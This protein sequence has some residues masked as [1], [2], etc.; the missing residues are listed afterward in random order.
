M[1]YKN[2]EAGEFTEIADRTLEET[3]DIIIK[4]PWERERNNTTVEPT[5]PSVSM[6]HPE[7]GIL[8]LGPSYHSKFRLYWL[9]P[10]G[11]LFAKNVFSLDE[12]IRIISGFYNDHDISEG[13]KKYSSF[14]KMTQHFITN[15]FVYTVTPKRILQYNLWHAIFGT[16]F[17]FFTIVAM[18]SQHDVDFWLKLSMI[19][20]PFVI[21]MHFSGVNWQFFF[22]YYRYSKNKCIIVSRGNDNFYYGEKDNLIEYSKKDIQKVTVLN[23]YGNKNPYTHNQIYTIT[24]K[25]NETIQIT[26]LLI[27]ESSFYRKIPFVSEESI[28]T[29]FPKPVR[30]S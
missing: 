21:W 24:L 25:N 12:A 9:Q 13:F 18:F 14:T 3:I 27:G 4:Y 23:Y 26:S 15:D 28:R 2:F 7:S 11:K 6:E 1:Q 17:L 10:S 20:A 19:L 22:N 30:K 8:K 16:P 29:Y 5:C